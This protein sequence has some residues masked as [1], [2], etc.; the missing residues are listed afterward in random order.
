MYTKEVARFWEDQGTRVHID[1]FVYLLCTYCVFIVYLLSTYC[2]P[3]V[4]IL[5]TFCVPI[6]YLLCTCC[7]PTHTHQGTC[8]HGDDR[9][10]INHS[11]VERVLK[12]GWQSRIRTHTHTR[13]YMR[14]YSNTHTHVYTY[15]RLCIP[16]HTYTHTHTHTHTD[17]RLAMN[18]AQIE[19]EL[20]ARSRPGADAFQSKRHELDAFIANSQKLLKVQ[21]LESF[22][23]DFDRDFKEE[24][25]NSGAD[26]VCVCVCLC[27]CVCARIYACTHSHTSTHT[28]THRW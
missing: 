8:V 22:L 21:E 27:M 2:V 15:M 23:A 5:C 26:E 9:L 4:C 25:A 11:K 16:T 12:F 10:T 18:D 17:D 24:V 19:N 7:V 20:I 28:H 13:I 1:V 6:V 14:V 3:I